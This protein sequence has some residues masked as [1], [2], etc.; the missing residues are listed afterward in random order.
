MSENCKLML[1]LYEQ[2]YDA[3]CYGANGVEE[4]KELLDKHERTCPI[5]QEN[6]KQWLEKELSGKLDE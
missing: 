5:C 3:Y 1:I 6:L 2:W 4:A